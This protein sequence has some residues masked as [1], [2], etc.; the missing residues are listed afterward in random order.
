MIVMNLVT[1]PR[2]YLV[3]RH[4]KLVVSTMLTHKGCVVFN[5]LEFPEIPGN[6]YINVHV[7]TILFGTFF[8]IDFVLYIHIFTLYNQLLFQS[9]GNIPIN[10]SFFSISHLV[11][12]TL[13]FHFTSLAINLICS[14]SFIDCF[15]QMI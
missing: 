4:W 9:S 12:Y 15:S 6:I 1:R 11:T 3:D 7:H 13:P 2:D 14:N 10:S 8:L 5:L